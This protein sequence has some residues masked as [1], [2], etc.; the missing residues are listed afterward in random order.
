MSDLTPI[1]REEM[2]LD[3]QDLTPITREEW[4]LKKAAEGGGGDGN[5]KVKQTPVNS[6]TFDILMSESAAGTG[7]KTEGAKKASSHPFKYNADDGVLMIGDDSTGA[8]GIKAGIDGVDIMVSVGRTYLN[9]QTETEYKHVAYITDQDI[10]LKSDDP[11]S[12]NT[13]DGTN[14]SLKA[15]LASL[16]PKEVTGLLEAGQ[17]SITLTDASITSSSTIDYYTDIFGV[18]P[19]TATV[20]TGSITLTFEAQQS[21]MNVK[22]RVS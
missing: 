15:A 12:P 16:K 18:N 21:D 9:Q 10:K 7:E 11:N 8:G 2:I 19:S 3:G 4:F 17:T 13:W 22:V 5:D 1:T 20:S 6:G 14:R